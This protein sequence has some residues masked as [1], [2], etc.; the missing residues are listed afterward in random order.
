MEG[1]HVYL[2]DNIDIVQLSHFFLAETVYV[3]IAIMQTLK[4]T[5]SDSSM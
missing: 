4:A 2:Q 1:I 5:F 3:F